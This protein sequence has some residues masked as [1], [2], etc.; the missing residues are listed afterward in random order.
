MNTSSVSIHYDLVVVGAGPAGMMAAGRAAALGAR[1]LLLE[2]GD[3]LGR[4]LAIAGGGRGNFTH[5]ASRTDLGNAFFG[6]TPA[7]KTQKY[8]N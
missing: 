4:K 2:K 6:K 3:S 7:R 5:A 1:I 8:T